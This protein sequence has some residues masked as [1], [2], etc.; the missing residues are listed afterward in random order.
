VTDSSEQEQASE[1]GGQVEAI[2]ERAA[3]VVR[4]FEAARDHAR[5]I[6]RAALWSLE[7]SDAPVRSIVR[8]LGEM[9]DLGIVDVFA[10]AASLAPMARAASRSGAGGMFGIEDVAAYA[11]LAGA[12]AAASQSVV[13]AQDTSKLAARGARDGIARLSTMQVVFVLVLVWLLTI[14]APFVQLALP[15]EAQTVVSN[16]YAT[17]GIAIAITLVIVQDRKR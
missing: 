11:G 5:P 7:N 16:E 12:T 2:K 13:R 1:L 15:P 3:E 9:V 4:E 8:Q 17:V 10:A 6:L 14:G